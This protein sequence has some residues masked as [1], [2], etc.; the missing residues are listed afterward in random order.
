PST[1]T[2]TS[3]TT[4]TPTFSVL[5]AGKDAS[6]SLYNL[7]P[8]LPPPQQTETAPTL[9]KGLSSLY[10]SWVGGG[11][12]GGGSGGGSGGGGGG[13]SGGGTSDAHRVAQIALPA[14]AQVTFRD[15]KRRILRLSVS[16]TL[17]GPTGGRR[18]VAAADALGRVLLFDC[19]TSAVV[20]IRTRAQ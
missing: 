17:P 15:A 3:T 14:T 8:H 11:T 6:L 20:R 2:S 16:P 7:G 1:T 12:G 18:L 4:T 9:F 13:G 10:N 19:E 5:A